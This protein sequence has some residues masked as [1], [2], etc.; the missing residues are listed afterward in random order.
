VNHPRAWFP[1]GRKNWWKQWITCQKLAAAVSN[2]ARRH[3]AT[4]ECVLLWWLLDCY[5]LEVGQR[6][7][8]RTRHTVCCLTVKSESESEITA[9]SADRTWLQWRTPLP[10]CKLYS[11]QAVTVASQYSRIFYSLAYIII[12]WTLVIWHWVVNTVGWLQSIATAPVC[13]TA[14]EVRASV[15]LPR[16]A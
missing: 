5:S 15:L 13:A 7:K 3:L 1:R 10:A 16:R 11:P 8:Q 2:I 9:E 4:T 12:V 14:M 6:R